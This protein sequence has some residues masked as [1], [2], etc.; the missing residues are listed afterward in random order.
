[1]KKGRGDVGTELRVLHQ[2][3]AVRHTEVSHDQVSHC[4]CLTHTHVQLM[5][6]SDLW[7]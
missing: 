3:G 6:Y 1:M 7:L 2:T 5:S 4:V